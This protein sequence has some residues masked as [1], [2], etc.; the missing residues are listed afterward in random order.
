MDWSA[1]ISRF[2]PLTGD[3]V[4][5]FAPPHDVEQAINS[6]NKAISNLVHDSQDIALIALRN[7]R[8]RL[9]YLQQAATSANNAALLAQNSYN[10]GLTDYQTVLQTQRT[11]LV[12]QVSVANMQVDLSSGHVR[13]I[14]AMGGGWVG[15][16]DRM[17]LSN[18]GK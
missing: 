4:T 17:T 6:Y 12:V 18:G 7:D 11:L 13:L 9:G 3:R 1:Q 2:A 16:A 8:E 14:K 5:A 15:E 10:S